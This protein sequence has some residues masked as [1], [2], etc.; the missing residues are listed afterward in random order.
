[1]ILSLQFEIIKLLNNS[2]PNIEE[3][4][5]LVM[6]DV[7]LTYQLLNHINTYT[8]KSLISANSIQHAIVEWG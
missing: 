2:A 1:M 3:V 7:S 4:A 8:F 6:R 5:A